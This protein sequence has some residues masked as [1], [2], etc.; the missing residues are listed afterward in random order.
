MSCG[1]TGGERFE[2][3]AKG[4]IEFTQKE[5]DAQIKLWAEFANRNKKCKI[6][7]DKEW[8]TRL[9]KG[10]LNNQARKGLKFCPCRMTLDD[11]EKDLKLIC[12][13]NFILQKTWKEKGECWCKLFLK[14]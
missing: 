12:P 11:K 9:A 8:V 7:P 13:C 14:A 2:K 10:V 4:K 3:M 1:R 5:I 6:N